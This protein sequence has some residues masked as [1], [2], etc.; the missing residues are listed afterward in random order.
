MVCL[1]LLHKHGLIAVA[2][3]TKNIEITKARKFK[4]LLLHMHSNLSQPLLQNDFLLEDRVLG[5]CD[6][7][8]DLG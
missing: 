4:G 6:N 1:Q 2:I 7:H 8:G 5:I 3:F